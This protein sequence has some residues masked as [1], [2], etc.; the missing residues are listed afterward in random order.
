MS[1]TGRGG[2][3]RPLLQERCLILTEVALSAVTAA[4]VVGLGRLFE[5]ASFLV[6]VLAFALAGHAVAAGCRRAGL[7]GAATTAVGTGVLVAAVSILLLPQSTRFGIPTGATLA[8]AAEQLGAA[9]STFREVVA[10]APVQPGF[11]LGAAITVWLLAFVA[12]TAA[13]RAR[14][15]LEAAVPGITLFVFAAALGAPRHRVSSSGLFL[16][17][18]IG[19]WLAQR[20]RAHGATPNLMAGDAG[21]GERA[22]LRSGGVIGLVAVAA[23][24]LVGPNL[25]GA[26]A[27]PV[28]PWRASD[29]SGPDSR[30]TISPLVDI[31]SRLVDQSDV[32]VFSVASP[33]RNYWRL[34]SLEIFDG[35]IWSSRGSYRNVEG[36][37]S[38]AVD[39]AAAATDRVVQDFEI[40]ALAS[41][42]LPAAY[43]P[44]GVEGV[45][46][47]YD[48]DSGSLLAE[49][50]SASGLRYQ[51]ASDVK[52]LAAA[53]LSA[54]PNVAPAEVAQTYTALPPALS[55][56]VVA[57][58]ARIVAGAATQYDRA[59]RLQD[60]FR[61]GEFTY[62]LSAPAGHAG[63]DLERF[64][65]ETRRGYC[66][67]FAGAYAA[68][69]RAVGLPARVAVGF[70][71]GELGP[72]GRFEVRG[73][74]AHAWPEVFF[75]GFGW[76]AFEPTPGRGI[77]G[78]LGYTGV[79]EQQASR[80]DPTT[81]TTVP[82][83]AP[84][85]TIAG[86]GQAGPATTAAPR[87]GPDGTG[88]SAGAADGG[89]SWLVRL[90]VA[91][92]VAG[93]VVGLWAGAISLAA[94]HRRIRRRA[95]ATS[96]N[97]RVLVA[98]AEVGEALARTGT[99]ARPSETPIEY[100]QRAA[101]ATGV[102]HRLLNALA[103]VTCAAGYGAAG[104]D[105]EVVGQ[106]VMAA[107]DVERRLEERLDG[108]A[109]LLAAVDPRPLL[110][111]RRPRIDISS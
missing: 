52:T 76:V 93:A 101:G 79:P 59:R 106:A 37:L 17:A 96:S 44:V 61:S 89:S 65:F 50:E 34:T 6:P 103:G 97:D 15:P 47:R 75:S 91:L 78:A 58:A 109:R 94:R 39:S 26:S 102:D 110:P 21:P 5:D 12:D 8:L 104:I 13:F 80:D 32:E 46:A 7:S 18:L 66:E 60:H 108:R 43:A 70:T 100:A 68:M 31:R 36:P 71:S 53:D 38:S 99:P 82:A 45:E 48:D 73:L 42:W 19:Y 77:P 86:A 87:P 55:D 29:R 92:L 85:T 54:V 9:V 25:P 88:A 3:A 14:A 24:L 22:L 1:A 33:S 10:P 107:A 16:L 81:A 64:L 57:E 27:S 84:S 23:A 62:D 49:S 40:G 83:P 41:I 35:R 2:P 90:V 51:V 111:A 28:V 20:V 56:A 105:D 95:A 30:V 98:W 69:A 4:A 74:N 63:D 67:Q 11:V 72:D